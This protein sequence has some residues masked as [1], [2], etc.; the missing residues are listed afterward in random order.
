META[1]RKMFRKSLPKRV[2]ILWALHLVVLSFAYVL[3]FG[4][5]FDFAVP[6]SMAALMWSTLVWVL[7]LKVAVF[8]RL[9]SFHSWWR[10]VSFADL[11]AILQ[12]SA[13]ATVAVAAIDHF[14]ISGEQIPRAV[15]LLD[16][17]LTL[18]L[19]GGIRCAV[20]LLREEFWPA[21]TAKSRRP[22]LVIGAEQGGESL[23]RQIH[24]QPGLNYRIVGFLD[25][26]AEHR[27]SRIGRIPFLGTPD[28]A[29]RLADERGIR[30][31][32]VIAGALPGARMRGLVEQCRAAEINL[33]VVPPIDRFLNGSYQLHIRDVKIDD[34]LHRDPVQLDRQFVGEMIRGRRVMVTGA[35]G[36]I[37]SEICRQ[38][39]SCQPEQLVLVDHG[40]NSLFYL[41]RELDKLVDHHLLAPCIGDIGDVE[42]MRSIFEHHRPHIVF[43]AAAHKHVPM[44][45]D[46]PGE[47]VKNNVFGTQ[48]LADLAGEFGVERFVLI[49]TDKAVNPT[50]VMG[51]TKQIAER[52]VHALSEFSGTRYI[53]VRF[54][55]VLGSAGSVV[56]I[57]REQIRGGGPVTV[58]HPKMERF[59]MTIPEASQLVL[60]A[61]AMGKGGEI[62]VLEMGQPVKIV[63]L[64]R[65][66]IRLSG[67]APGEIEIQF[68]GMRP[69][70]KLYEELYFDTERLLP[71]AHPKLR[72]AE[73]RP[74]SLMEL[75][76]SLLKLEFVV[77]QPAD[78]VRETLG[79]VVPEYRGREPARDGA[80]PLVQTGKLLAQNAELAGKTLILS[81]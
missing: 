31:I 35:G 46:N 41:K 24:S 17:G 13:L 38:V 68:S 26:N 51:A 53:V 21:L 79:R 37:G 63:D 64:A 3:A 44:M 67:A 56:P 14:V 34:L 2:Y 20:R 66:M 22:A 6:E 81:P 75:R 15:L 19:L 8:Y 10:Y 42:R 72:A 33:R 70:E 16:F 28:D 43:H 23:V 49:S 50:S 55:N 71:T 58:T 69:G 11:A 1:L 48:R 32:L 39:L 77:D 60:Q 57:F 4:L 61:A 80:A 54:G 78:V 47:A 52:Y 40:E 9:G 7:P 74:I 62:F 36:S 30:D 65:D 45:E 18:L 76:E 27:G 5:Q 59:F 25:E 29:A 12:A 73:H